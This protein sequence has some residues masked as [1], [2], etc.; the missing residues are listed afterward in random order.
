MTSTALVSL[1]TSRRDALHKIPLDW[2]N[3]N[4]KM[5]PLTVH[6][7]FMPYR[8]DWESKHLCCMLVSSKDSAA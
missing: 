5:K 7:T 2:A 3:L 8:D 4:G 6:N 1:G